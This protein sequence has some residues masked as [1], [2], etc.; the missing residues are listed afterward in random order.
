MIGQE[1]AFGDS[2]SVRYITASFRPPHRPTTQEGLV[3]EYNSN[4][5]GGFARIIIDELDA[6]YRGRVK[7]TLLYARLP[8]LYYDIHSGDIK[9]AQKPM[10]V[11]LFNWPFTVLLDKHPMR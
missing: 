11:E 3:L 8:S 7:G 4:E 6:R 9:S 5:P 1:M 2:L 10:V